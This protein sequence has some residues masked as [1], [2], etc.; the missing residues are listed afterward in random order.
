[1]TEDQIRAEEV[2]YE[3]A[4]LVATLASRLLPRTHFAKEKQLEDAVYAA[5]YL[6]HFSEKRVEAGW[7][8]DESEP[9]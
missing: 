7:E 8:A 3:R 4:V 2:R 1:M 6:L 5:D 9:A